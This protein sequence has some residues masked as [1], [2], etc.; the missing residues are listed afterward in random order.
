MRKTSTYARKRKNDGLAMKVAQ[1]DN[2]AYQAMPYRVMSASQPF[3]PDERLRL[4]IPILTA[5]QRLLDG[6]AQESDF[7]T[8]GIVIN[9]CGVI[10]SDIH[11]QIRAQ[12][13]S[14]ATALACVWDRYEQTGEFTLDDEAKGTLPAIIELHDQL[15]ELCQPRQLIEAMDTANQRSRN[16]AGVVTQRNAKQENTKSAR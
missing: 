7:H 16:Q 2:P 3:T 13:E 6:V 10:A 4:S 8:M 12:I 11:P 5:Y 1:R 14:A 15:L 9:V